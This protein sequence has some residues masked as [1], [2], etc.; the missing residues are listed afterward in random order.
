MR[1][2]IVVVGTSL[3]GLRALQALLERLPAEFSLPIAIVQ[4]RDTISGGG[5]STILQDHSALLV[6]EPQDKEPILPGR[7]YL[8][9][10]DY[11]LLAEKGRFALSTDGP[12]HNSRPSI[13][14]L[15]ESAA[16]AYGE[17][18]VGVVLT[19]ANQDGAAG[20]ARIRS[21]GGLVVAQDPETAEVPAMPKAAIAAGADK[22]LPLGEIAGFL[23]ALCSGGK[24]GTE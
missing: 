13:D 19:G 3:G 18:V 17:G 8:A 21:R 9:P 1:P 15:F 4:H 16:D 2:G 12:V 7:V 5:L 14:V 22:T 10:A 11:H 23:I 20:S 6:S 24:R